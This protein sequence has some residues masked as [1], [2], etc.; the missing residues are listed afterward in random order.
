MRVG[1]TLDDIL[2]AYYRDSDCMNKNYYSQ[3][4]SVLFGKL[5]YGRSASS[6]AGTHETSDAEYKSG[7]DL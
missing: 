6:E 2:K 4:K 1:N 7:T 3:D 5:L